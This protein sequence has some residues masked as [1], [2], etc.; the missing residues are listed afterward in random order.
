MRIFAAIN[1]LKPLQKRLKMEY[2]EPC[3]VGRELL[4]LL[5]EMPVVPFQ[6]NGNVTLEH[7]MK[8]LSEF[9]GNE[10][11]ITLAV[12]VI[13]IPMLR[14]LAWYYRRGWTKNVVI[15]TK[16]NQMELIAKELEGF[17]YTAVVNPEMSE[18]TL[19]MKGE[20]K[21][22]VIQGDILG[23]VAPKGCKHYTGSIT[24]NKEILGMMLDTLEMQIR[25]A[26]REAEKS[27]VAERDVETTSS[28][29][30]EGSPVMKDDAMTGEGGN[31]GVPVG[32]NV[33][34]AVVVEGAAR[35]EDG[36]SI[37]TCDDALAVE[38]G[39]VTDGDGAGLGIAAAVAEEGD[40]GSVGHNEDAAM[41]DT[42]DGGVAEDIDAVPA[43]DEE[44]SVTVT[45][46][47]HGRRNRKGKGR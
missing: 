11:E 32:G 3:C 5:K 20:L 40:D 35:K 44:G 38:D 31:D 21:T 7:F 29:E 46:K 4:A 27:E 17:A 25:K 8:G 2:M 1:R 16:E 24:N 30:G 41:S 6:T 36:G 15:M 10:L 45:D 19:V 22:V 28:W 39:T 47:N 34:V 33:E 13:D 37:V 43:L 42:G 14:M 23:T 9:A 18:G 26:E 12:P